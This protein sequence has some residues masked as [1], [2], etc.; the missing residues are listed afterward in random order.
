MKNKQAFTLIELLVVVLIIG[1]L[2]AV[3]VPQYQKAVDKA[4]LAQIRPFINGIIQA[5][6]VYYLANGIYAYSFDDLDI[7]TTQGPCTLGGVYDIL[8][9]KGLILNMRNTDHK[10][11]AAALILRYCPTLTNPTYNTCT[12][13]NIFETIYRFPH[14]TGSSGQANDTWVCNAYTTRGNPLKSVFCP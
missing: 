13:N 8:N 7:D 5:Q 3:A 4:R 11:E 14:A 1:I 10:A 6:H 9:C 2:A 12:T